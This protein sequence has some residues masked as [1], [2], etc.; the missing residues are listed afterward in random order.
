MT[1]YATIILFFMP[2]V[3]M[4]FSLFCFQ[5]ETFYRT[6][7]AVSGKHGWKGATPPKPY[8]VLTRGGSRVLL[9]VP[10]ISHSFGGVAPFHIDPSGK[11]FFTGR[12]GVYSSAVRWARPHLIFG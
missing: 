12:A 11:G 9:F 1:F 6:R 7:F 3:N 4:P 2:L 5:L 10:Q 8:L